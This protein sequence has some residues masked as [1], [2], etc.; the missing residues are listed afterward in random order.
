MEK[1]LWPKIAF[2]DKCFLKT[3]KKVIK[4]LIIKPYPKQKKLD[5]DQLGREILK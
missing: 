5:R 4:K 1:K 2:S 3:P